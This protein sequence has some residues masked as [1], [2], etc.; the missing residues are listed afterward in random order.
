MLPKQYIP[1]NRLM[2]MQQTMSSAQSIQQNKILNN[3]RPQQNNRD[4]FKRIILD[5]RPCDPKIDMGRFKSLVDMANR[6]SSSEK[7]EQLWK[8]RD[9]AP[10]KTIIPET[11]TGAKKDYKTKEELVVYK[12]TKAD[13]DKKMFE[14]CADKLKADITKQNNDLSELYSKDDKEKHKQDFEY[15]NKN[16]YTEKYNP[17]EFSDLKNVAIE[18]FKK[19]QLEIEQNK[20]D[21]TEIIEC[22]LANEQ[23]TRDSP[24][25]KPLSPDKYAM[26]QKKV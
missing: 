8:G 24:P 19:D 25:S 13:K 14:D 4:D 3:P 9:N 26:R 17:A 22:S 10:Y 16:K 5:Q 2:A 18:Q 21:M 20:H 7:R 6:N 12:T 15:Q 1:P 11:V 23:E